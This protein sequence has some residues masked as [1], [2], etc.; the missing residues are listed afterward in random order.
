VQRRSRTLRVGDA[1]RG[2]R[3]VEYEARVDGA[4]AGCTWEAVERGEPHGRV[5]G[6]AGTDCAGGCAGAEVKDD[7]V[8]G[9]GGLGGGLIW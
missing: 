3:V 5:E 6:A 4:G 1:S 2:V 9:F 7:K 8:E